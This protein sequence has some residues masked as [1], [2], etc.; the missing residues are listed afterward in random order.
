MNKHGEALGSNID[1]CVPQPSSP[2]N[3]P[4]ILIATAVGTNVQLDWIAST[5][6]SPSGYFIERKIAGGG[7]IDLVLD[8]GT[9]STT[10]LDNTVIPATQFFYRVSAINAFGISAPSNEASVTTLETPDKPTLFAVQNGSKI[11]LSWTLPTSDSPINGFRVEKRINLGLF[12]DLVSNTTNTNLTLSD[13]N[14]TAGNVYGFRVRGLSEIGTGAVSNVV[15]VN[16]GSH[17]IVQVREQDGTSYKGGGSVIMANTTFSTSQ[18]ID[19]LSNA[20]FDNFEVGNYNFTFI[21]LDDF[22]LNRTINFPFPSG[23]LS[24]TFEI[25]ALVFDVDCPSNGGGT[26]VRIK[27]N[28]TNLHDITQFPSAPVCDSSDKISW[29]TTWAGSEFNSTSTMIADFISVNF[30]ENAEQFLVS[31]VPTGTSYDSVANRITSD[32]Y[33]VVPQIP[34]TSQTINFDLFLDMSPPQGGSGG[35]GGGTAPFI[36]SITPRAEDLELTGLSL[37]SRTHQFAQAGDIIRGFIDIQ[38]EGEDPLTITR[39][40]IGDFRGSMVFLDTPRFDIP[41]SIEGSG[42]FAMSSGSVPYVI[43][44]PPQVCQPE[45]GLD[46]NCLIQELFSIPVEFE[47]EFKGQTVTGSTNIVV[48]ASPVP[49]DIVQLQVILLGVLLIASALAG[50]FIRQR[51]KKQRKPATKKRRKFKKKFDSS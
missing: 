12:F 41:Q 13:D 23:N 3:S 27:V 49:F 35:G 28:Y 5:E 50:N 31:T 15:D 8:T 36:P 26:D 47:F 38:W 46:Q 10:F 22:I 19:V 2:P 42:E 25:R 1:T 45:I 43:T 6:G 18:V 20:N 48:D 34:Q 17:V 7:Y 9:T 33:G 21:D 4:T 44:L 39:I 24:N 16:F 37:L 51:I 29:S 30:M 11:D 14:L 32:M 40:T